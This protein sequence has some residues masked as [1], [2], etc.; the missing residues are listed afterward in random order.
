MNSLDYPATWVALPFLSFF[1]FFVINSTLK[2][3]RILLSKNKL[4]FKL[5]FNPKY[6]KKREYLFLIGLLFFFIL[7][8]DNPSKFSP[9]ECVEPIEYVGSDDTYQADKR[10]YCIKQYLNTDKEY[11]SI[12]DI[13]LIR[14]KCEKFKIKKEDER[15]KSEARSENTRLL[16]SRSGY[17]C[18]TPSDGYCPDGYWELELFSDGKVEHTHGS[19]QTRGNWTPVKN[20][21]VIY[22][23]KIENNYD[24]NGT[25]LLEKHNHANG[26]GKAGYIY[27]KGTRKWFRSKK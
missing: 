4:E 17:Y 22:G 21:I 8:M 19:Y 26:I 24:P 1:T 23:L 11:N 16:Y 10:D 20:G 27:Q 3:L 14:I 5:F 18:A 12:S 2:V 13:E 25:W 9:C 6:Y 15:I 7:L